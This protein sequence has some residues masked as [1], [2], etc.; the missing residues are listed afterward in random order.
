[1]IVPANHSELA[2]NLTFSKDI[3]FTKETWKLCFPCIVLLLAAGT[4][5]AI[6]FLVFACNYQKKQKHE[7]GDYSVGKVM[8]TAVI[9]T[10]LILPRL[11]LTLSLSFIGYEKTVESDRLCEML[12]DFSIAAFGVGLLPIYTYLWIRQRALYLQPF[13]S[14]LYTKPVKLLSWSLLVMILTGDVLSIIMYVDPVTYT[15]SSNGCVNVQKDLENLPHYFGVCLQIAGQVLLLALYLY[16]LIKHKQVQNSYL[17]ST[18]GN[19]LPTSGLASKDRVL[20]AV[21][22]SFWC[23]FASIISAISSTVVASVI[24]INIPRVVTNIVF[25]LS[26]ILTVFFLI[27]SF[28]SYK[29][30]LTSPLRCQLQMNTSKWSCL[31]SWSHFR[32]KCWATFELLLLNHTTEMYKVF[33]FLLCFGL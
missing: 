32:W 15:S 30:I 25:D 23:A 7:Q 4:W 21:Q 1:M 14:S 12:M 10:L 6:S 26:L 24:S 9:S 3:F 5:M 8:I 2:K 31:Y 19:N 11:A 18:Y 29:L 17:R 20:L 33:S 22:R 16:P 28:E 27:V 13:I